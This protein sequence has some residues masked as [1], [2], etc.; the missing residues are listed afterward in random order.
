MAG[1]QRQ[2]LRGL[3]I[4]EGTTGRPAKVALRPPSTPA[5]ASARAK[6]A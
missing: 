3:R 1:F 2:T 6:K 5:Q 4:A